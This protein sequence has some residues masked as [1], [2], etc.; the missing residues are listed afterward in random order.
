MT[1]PEIPQLWQRAFGLAYFIFPDRE[2]ALAI[3]AR[4]LSKLEVA[5]NA[6]F[7]RLYYAPS[8]RSDPNG[9]P[10]Q[11]YRTKVVLPEAQLLQ[12]LIYTEAEPFERA[13][14]RGEIGPP[15][16]QEDMVI[17]FIKHLVRIST[18]RTSFYVNLAISRLLHDYTT[19]ESMDLYGLV[20][21]DPERIRNSD[22]YRSRKKQLMEE[23]RNRFQKQVEVERGYRNELRFARQENPGR[24]KDLVE[25]S[26]RRFS[27]WGT[28]CV[29]PNNLD[30]YGEGIPQLAFHGQDP[31]G[32]HA[33]EVNRM[34]TILHPECFQ[35]LTL[36][37]GMDRPE[38]RLA[39]PRFHASQSTGGDKQPNDRTNPP[40][41]SSLEADQI[42]SH[43]DDERNLR[44]R[45]RP[46]LLR[47]MVDGRL[48]AELNL[49]REEQ[50]A[51]NLSTASE[52]IEVRDQNDV[53]LGAHLI[54]GSE[55][56]EP[57]TARRYT[58]VLESGQCLRFEMML[59]PDQSNGETPIKTIIGYRETRLAG[60]LRLWWLRQTH[61]PRSGFIPIWASAAIVG[62]FALWF[63]RPLL[64]DKPTAAVETMPPVRIDFPD[65]DSPPSESLTRS[66]TTL[67]EGVA[68][69]A[70][71]K[72]HILS[73]G[74]GK[75]DEELK[76]GLEQS[77]QACD[78]FHLTDDI[79]E[80]DAVLKNLAHLA[81]PGPDGRAPDW[82]LVLAN[83]EGKTLWDFTFSLEEGA[84][85]DPRDLARRA[86][87]DLLT[88]SAAPR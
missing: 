52:L 16:E 10:V 13:Q 61:R 12:R 75:R 46:G 81:K 9:K 57:G 78:R 47:V 45:A 82:Y 84:D 49:K 85:P 37:F 66:L 79:H 33:V 22:Y 88:Q 70:V 21:Q 27:P 69:A 87:G 24:F 41:L 18:R 1:T 73:M 38:L 4:A 56:L 83:A 23:C 71:S 31:D 77:I 63:L 39:V 51:V 15:V 36:A 59:D 5:A 3:A 28:S 2:M 64:Q 60:I 50:V 43:L 42:R 14:E 48:V 58:L 7:K 35:R 55:S 20:V 32:E 29:V 6:Q 44:Q 25:E 54:T 40:G 74:D 86:I 8:G 68:L 19:S 80:A 76:N 72:I 30:A 65:F 26:L 11:G 53:L 17:R 34:H 62:L 67:P